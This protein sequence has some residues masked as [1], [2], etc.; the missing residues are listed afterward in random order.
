[1]HGG[2]ASGIVIQLDVP[3]AVVSFGGAGIARKDPDFIPAYVVNHILGGGS[4]TSRLYARCARSAASP[5]ASIR[6]LLWMRHAACSSAAPQTRA[7]RTREALELIEAR[8]SA[9]PT[10]ARPR[11]SSPRPRPISRAPMRSNFDTSTKIASMLLQIQ[12]D[13]LGIDYIDKRNALI[14]AVT[15][16]DAGAPPSGCRRRHAGHGGRPAARD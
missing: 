12:L 16:E 8:S 5:M 3:Q 10:R 6:Y 11:R 1:M 13:D 4:F 2:S 7:D 15:I 9:W 14:D